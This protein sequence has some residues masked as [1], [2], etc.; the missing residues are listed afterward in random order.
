MI[1]DIES[2]G[3]S[4]TAIPREKFQK[5]TETVQ[6]IRR[7]RIQIRVRKIVMTKRGAKMDSLTLLRHTKTTERTFAVPSWN[8]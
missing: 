7:L 8:R 3:R 2:L 6:K 4:V 1:G 5:P